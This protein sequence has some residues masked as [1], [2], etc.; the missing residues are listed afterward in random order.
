[1]HRR[2]GIY[3]PALIVFAVAISMIA[4][5]SGGSGAPDFGIGDEDVP[6]DGSVDGL[7]VTITNPPEGK[8]ARVSG[9]VEV[10][11]RIDNPQ[12]QA[13][14]V[15]ME[16]LK[17]TA[18]TPVTKDLAG[19]GIVTMSLDTTKIPDGRKWT[20]QVTATS[21][22]NSAI[23]TV[24]LTIDNA[25]PSIEA[26]EPTPPEG[27]NFL[28]DL[29]VRFMVKDPGAGLSSVTIKV[30]SFTY[31]WPGSGTPTQVDTGTISV[32]GTTLTSG[33]KTLTVEATDDLGRKTTFERLFSYS[34]RP[35]FQSGTALALPADLKGLAI[36]GIRLADGK[37]GV[38]VAGTTGLT[39]FTRN[40]TSG[41][42]DKRAELAKG[43]SCNKVEVRD[44][45]M[46]GREDLVVSC[47]VWLAGVVDVIAIFLQAEDASFGKPSVIEVSALVVAFSLGDMN[48]D[49]LPDIAL[50]LG[51]AD[52][53][54]GLSLSN[55]ANG[56][57][58]KVQKYGGAQ[59]PAFVAVGRFAVVPENNEYK[60]SI[61]LAR[62]GSKVVTLFSMSALGV[63]SSGVNGVLDSPGLSAMVAT[64]FADPLAE[65]D[66]LVLADATSGRVNTAFLQEGSSVN[67]KV[68]TYKNQ[69]LE[70]YSAGVEPR[71][72]D[73]GDLDRDG[74]NDVA[75][76]CK[77]GN[78]VHVFHGNASS[79][80]EN[81]YTDFLVSGPAMLSGPVIDLTLVDF[82]G[83]DADQDK[84]LDLVLLSAAGTSLVFIPFDVAT[85]LY[86]GTPV[87]LAPVVPAS[88][89]AGKFTKRGA[90]VAAENRDV[91]L[92]GKDDKGV[93]TLVF[94]VSDDR[95]TNLPMVPAAEKYQVMIASQRRIVA[96]NLDFSTQK[97]VGLDDLILTTA[98]AGAALPP[99][100]MTASALIFKDHNQPGEDPHTHANFSETQLYAGE[101]PTLA[102]AGDMFW[103]TAS[104]QTANYP[105]YQDLAFIG[106]FFDVSGNR[107]Q[108]LQ[109]FYRDEAS[110]S[111]YVLKVP[112][113]V[114]A[115]VLVGDAKRPAA[116]VAV[117][118]RRSLARALRGE[119]YF[120]DILSANSGTGDF[121]VYPNQG[122]GFL[123]KEEYVRDFAIG[124]SA[125]AIAAGYLSVPF[126]PSNPDLVPQDQRDNTFPD[127]VTLVDQDV[128]IS[129]NTSDPVQLGLDPMKILFAPPQPL[130]HAGLGPVD[131]A[132]V[133]MNNDRFLDIVVLNG[134]DNT[135][136]V[137]MNL[138]SKTFSQPFVFQTGSG[139]VAMAIADLDGN[140]CPDIATAD[141]EGRTVTLLRNQV[142]CAQ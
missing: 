41:G 35:N 115:T 97:S 55:A 135:V 122:S 103:S 114:R 118:L 28:G 68:G 85:Q 24:L 79:V 124:A 72:I 88:I 71:A 47:P 64:S 65:P 75:V 128:M 78:L 54:M 49:Q 10:S 18:F 96:A 13:I 20:L 44:L 93:D 6:A 108:S 57:W 133:D 51:D 69:G 23:K 141:Q 107:N 84:T 112:I 132:V 39:L 4:C 86:R 127:V 2:T 7:Q 137:Y 82:D 9:T 22:D 98:N 59:Q 76:L 32:P 33:V 89:A 94:W 110:S 101:A 34:Q 134:I 140:G 102:T 74:T 116:L 123:Y 70:L 73:V 38:L 136:A 131:L 125:I 100:P 81:N 90:G 87:L 8:E 61:L 14:S 12:K 95:V 19:P 120:M 113:G 37:G 66:V 80:V 126:D 109:V 17:A 1:M 58:G 52:R 11:I 5:N 106:G 111:E 50:A 99:H 31:S 36:G 138:G 62:S 83:A 121:S 53:S 104:G 46:D 139:P 56:T 42:L 129:Y 21:D 117:Q 119:Q 40:P 92:L 48:N 15:K 26:L 16:V 25:E 29:A 43:V 3:F 142:P 27:G 63:M 60:N 45:N 130:G 77:G 91:V 30:D 105:G 67:F